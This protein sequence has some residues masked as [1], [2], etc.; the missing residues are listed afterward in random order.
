ML[1]VRVNAGE[2]EAIHKSLWSGGV[3]LFTTSPAL[4][5]RHVAARTR[6][7][8]QKNVVAYVVGVTPCRKPR[9]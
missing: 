3:E 5:P 9:A 2:V 7:Q 6:I 1:S 8:E 4:P